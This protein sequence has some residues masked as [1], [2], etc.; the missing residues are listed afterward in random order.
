MN[1]HTKLTSLAFL[2]A[3]AITPATAAAA[4]APVL[5]IQVQSEVDNLKYSTIAAPG[6]E[7]LNYEENITCS[8]SWAAKDL[9]TGKTGFL[10]AGHCGKSGDQV[11]I[12][13]SPGVE[14]PIGTIEWSSFETN[15]KTMHSIDLAFVSIDT[16]TLMSTQVPG[17]AKTPSRVMNNVDYKRIMPDLCKIGQMT[18]TTCG[19]SETEHSTMQRA[20]FTAPSYPGDSGGPVY[21]QTKT[22]ELVA[23][24]VFVGV[25]SGVED[26]ASAQVLSQ[27]VLDIYQFEVITQ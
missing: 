20:T 3:S 17:I 7:F 9:S 21:A 22:G 19:D 2:I 11:V 23:V 14:T 12:Q 5:P 1:K 15:N 13:S 25:P 16:P 6:V 4:D 26:V 18:G 27:D 24:G 8:F 10:T